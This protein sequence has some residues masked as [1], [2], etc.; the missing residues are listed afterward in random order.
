MRPFASTALIP[1]SI[2]LM[3]T[4]GMIVFT[5]VGPSASSSLPT[6]SPT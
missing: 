5:G 6:R 4:L 3:T 2:F 1:L